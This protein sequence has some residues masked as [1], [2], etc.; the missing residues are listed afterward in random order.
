MRSHENSHRWRTALHWLILYLNFYTTITSFPFL[1]FS[2]F[3]SRQRTYV[4]DLK[5]LLHGFFDIFTF[6]S[7]LF[8]Y[9]CTK[10]CNILIVDNLKSYKTADVVLPMILIIQN[11]YRLQTMIHSTNSFF[12]PPFSMLH[13]L[14][15]LHKQLFGWCGVILFIGFCHQLIL[16]V[17]YRIPET[18][19]LVDEHIIFKWP[20]QNLV[21]CYG[22]WSQILKY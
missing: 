17:G 15:I 3:F 14:S 1:N 2:I 16:L 18:F 21:W 12:L 6:L 10:C 7:H 8:F 11:N 19:F 13:T 5:V 20:L 4:Y 9:C 22:E